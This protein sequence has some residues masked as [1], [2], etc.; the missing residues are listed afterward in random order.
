VRDAAPGTA[1]C[2]DRRVRLRQELARR[3]ARA[4]ASGSA[5][6]AGLY[7]PAHGDA[8]YARLAA[9]ARDLLLAGYDVVVDAANL[10]RAQR[11]RFRALADEL[12]TGLAWLDCAAPEALLRER[13]ASRRGDPSE[14]TV[15]VLERQLARREPLDDGERARAVL[16]R[17]DAP[18]DVPAIA[19]ALRAAAAP[20]AGSTPAS[21]P[22]T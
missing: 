17:T 7:A 12:C 19:A 2:D 18:V 3:T 1:V 10:A 9:S 13:V 11:A 20:P 22:A 21:A 4:V 8:T 15:E 6:D 16:A 5:P 14:A